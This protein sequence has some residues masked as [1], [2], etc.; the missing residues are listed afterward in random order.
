M[1]FTS[2]NSNMVR[3]K[4]TID[5]KLA[6]L[7]V[8]FNSNMV[9]LKAAFNLIF[10]FIFLEF[11]FQYGAIKRTLPASLIFYLFGF[12]SNMVRLKDVKHG[13]FYYCISMI[14]QKSIFIFFF[15]KSSMCK[16]TKTPCFRQLIPN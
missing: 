1:S 9:R 14:Y 16:N 8:C 11:Q 13:K 15:N 4:G 2:F 3:L 5:N 10:I 12:N 6:W 7:F